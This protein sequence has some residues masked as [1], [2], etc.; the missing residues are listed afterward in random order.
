MNFVASLHLQILRSPIKKIIFESLSEYS[1][2]SSPLVFLVFLFL[3]CYDEKI[4]TY[5]VY[6]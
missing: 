4:V 1:I 6:C 2:I 5:S 3:F